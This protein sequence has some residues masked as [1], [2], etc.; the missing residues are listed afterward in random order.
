MR[1][2]AWT[3]EFEDCLIN[4]ADVRRR[5]GL[6]TIDVDP[7][8]DL[9]PRQTAKLLDHL[10]KDG[11]LSALGVYDDSGAIDYRWPSSL[12]GLLTYA[13]L[14]AMKDVLCRW[15]RP[16][17][18]AAMIDQVFKRND[19][20]HSTREKYANYYW[21]NV[22]FFVQDE[23]VVR[24]LVGRVGVN[25]RAMT[26]KHDLMYVWI[27]TVAEDDGKGVFDNKTIKQGKKTRRTRMRVMLYGINP[28]NLEGAVHDLSKSI[29]G[30]PGAELATDGVD[31][32]GHSSFVVEKVKGGGRGKGGEVTS[33]SSSSPRT[34]QTRASKKGG[35]WPS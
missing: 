26:E 25:F 6:S 23:S 5:L 28:P 2:T 34:R 20:S 33:S 8:R 11:D 3:S 7:D 17:E 15:P 22:D 16:S 9:T 13:G 14:S 31:V 29:D 10:E 24:K 27:D 32:R 30:S 18:L 21:R 12:D 4:A 1:S 19:I 35:V